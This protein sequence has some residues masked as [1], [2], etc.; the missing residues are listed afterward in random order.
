[1]STAAAIHEHNTIGSDEQTEQLSPGQAIWMHLLPGAFIM[2]TFVLL[3]WLF[4]GSGMLTMNVFI[5]AATLALIGGQFGYLYYQGWKR[6]GRISL[7][8][9]V[10]YREPLPVRTYLWLV[11]VVLLA[12]IALFIGLSFI[13]SAL[14]S[15]L[16]TWWPAAWD[17]SLDPS[18][19]SRTMS[20]GSVLLM[21]L[22]VNLAG[23]IVEELYF[24]G[25][26]LP[27]L[28]RYGRLAPVINGVLFAVYHFWSPWAV[29]SRSIAILPLTYSVYR[30]KNI[31][32]GI[33]VHCSLN[34]IGSIPLLLAVL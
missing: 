24:R 8:G 9:I 27:R 15:A 18:T 10:R 17:L 5:I 34:C 22:A 31:M 29:I 4:S 1:M 30:R 20:L 11:P 32:V 33:L 23:P 3:S 16:F 6:N 25:Y 14:F 7:E 2:S 28:E 13:D 12:S 19:A 21:Y 26:L